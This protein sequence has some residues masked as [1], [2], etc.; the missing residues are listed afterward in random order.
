MYNV[1]CSLY[2]EMAESA[3]GGRLLSDYTGLN[4]YRGFESLSLRHFIKNVPVA[5]LDR[6]FDYESKGRRFE[7]CRARHI[8]KTQVNCRFAKVKDF[9]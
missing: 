3:E 7:S 6:V 2:G 1:I 9:R 4:L 5:Q 8:N